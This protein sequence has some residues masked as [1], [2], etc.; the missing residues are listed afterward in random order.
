MLCVLCLC[1]CFV[2]VCVCDKDACRQLALIS[3]FPPFAVL[4][5]FVEDINMVCDQVLYLH[6]ILKGLM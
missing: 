2:L 5:M 3:I 1:V 4:G 6:D